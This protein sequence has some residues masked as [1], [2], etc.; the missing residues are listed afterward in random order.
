MCVKRFQGGTLI[1]NVH[2]RLDTRELYIISAQIK[3]TADI[4]ALQLT[5]ALGIRIRIMDIAIQ[6]S[7]SARMKIVSTHIIDRPTDK[8]KFNNLAVHSKL[9]TANLIL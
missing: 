3:T 7:K 5:Q 9:I 4:G 8:M 2:F 1:N 6:I